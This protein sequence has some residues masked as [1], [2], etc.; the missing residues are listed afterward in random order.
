MY[1]KQKSYIPRFALLI[2]C[3]DSVYNDEINVLYIEKSSILKAEKLSNYFIQTAKKIKY[4]SKEINDLKTVS[5]KA[6]TTVDKLK[7]IYK[8]DPEFNRSKV[9]E[10]LGVSRQQ[11]LRLLKKIEEN[12]KES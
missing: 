9:A 11:V 1:P 3:F 8:A 12:E 10:L 4:E 7:A 6:E 5:K 2:N